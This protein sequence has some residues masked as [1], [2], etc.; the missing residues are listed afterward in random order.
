MRIGDVIG[1]VVLSRR[2]ESLPHARL[3][4]VRPLTLAGLRGA[5]PTWGEDLVLFDDLGAGVGS[6]VGLSEGREAANPFHPKKV[7]IDA[8]SACLIDQIDL[9]PANEQA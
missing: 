1:R 9:E 2:H 3:L 7:P 8:Y 4:I 5:T 6:R